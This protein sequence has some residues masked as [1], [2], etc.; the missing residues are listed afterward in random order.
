MVYL[1]LCQVGKTSG[2]KKMRKERDT[3]TEKRLREWWREMRKQAGMRRKE[4]Q[5]GTTKE[6]RDKDEEEEWAEGQRP[7][8]T[9]QALITI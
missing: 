5:K 2:R 6:V 4:G 8:D 7:A 3:E 1:T 9:L